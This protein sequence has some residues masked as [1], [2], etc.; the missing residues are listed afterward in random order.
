VLEDFRNLVALQRIDTDLSRLRA[1][2]DGLPGRRAVLEAERAGAEAAVASARAALAE[3]EHHL[4]KL[5]TDL[6]DKE[7]LR[8]RLTGQQHQVKSNDAYTALLAEMEA[9]R[10]AISELEDASLASMEAVDTARAALAAAEAERDAAQARVAERLVG[11]EVRERE[12]H[13]ALDEGGG[14]RAEQAGRVDPKL[15]ARYD[16]VRGHRGTGAV[17]LDRQ[18]C[19]GC[20]VAIPAQDWNRLLSGEVIVGCSQCQRILIAERHLEA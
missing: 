16:R 11:L 6:Q 10:G 18:V 9:A 15:L 17:V 1:E 4:R 12:L 7:T 3:A 5:E 8:D 19:T 20:G 13:A 2:A 14:R